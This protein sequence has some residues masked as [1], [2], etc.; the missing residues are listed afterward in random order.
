MRS[1]SNNVAIATGG[2][3][4]I[5]KEVA[6]R[7]VEAGASIVIGGRDV[8]EAIL[9]LASNEASW[10]TDTVLPVD[11]GVIAGRN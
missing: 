11:G 2:G 4:G 7:L 8:A 10:I 3:S 5:G 9:F 1:F 6:K